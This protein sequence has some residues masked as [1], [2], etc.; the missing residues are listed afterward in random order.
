MS[1]AEAWRVAVLDEHTAGT[2]LF[3]GVRCA[4]A[5]ANYWTYGYFEPRDHCELPGLLLRTRASAQAP[6]VF[7]APGFEGE[8]YRYHPSE[9]PA[10]VSWTVELPP[11]RKAA[12]RPALVMPRPGPWEV[13][14]EPRRDRVDWHV[15]AQHRGRQIHRTLSGPLGAGHT[16]H[17]AAR[18][19]ALRVTVPGGA[20]VEVEHDAY[21]GPFMVAFGSA[22]A[23]DG[24]PV[25]TVYREVAV[26]EVPYPCADSPLPDG[27]EDLRAADDAWCFLVNE[28]TPEG[29]RQSEGDLAVLS[30]GSLLL[31]WTDYH[32][33]K[34]WD[35]SPA[36]LSARRSTDGGRT[37]SRK[38]TVVEEEHDTNV[39]SASLLNLGDELLLVYYDQLPDMPAKGMVARRSGD[40]GRSWSAA[41][42]ITPANGNRHAANNASLRRLADGRILLAAR[43]YVD[44]VR[45]PYCLLSDDGGRTWRAGSHV[46]DPGL[47]ER[48]RRAQ[49]V[50]EPSV[51]QLADGR[52][53][54]TMRS[55]SGGQFFACSEDRGQ[56][57]SRPFLSPLRGACSPAAIQRVPGTADVLCLWTY[58]LSGRTPL[59]SALSS[60]AGRSWRALKLVERSRHHGYCYTSIT[61]HGDR[62]LLTY[63][64]F[65][66]LAGLRRFA[67]EPGYIDL[68]LTALPVEW[69]YRPVT[70]ANWP[71]VS[72]KKPGPESNILQ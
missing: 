28:A 63:S 23:A 10:Y 70:E 39:M 44:G 67:V 48:E 14:A 72:G 32:A 41:A 30:D 27:P 7:F 2:G 3:Q 65:P 16:V 24:S 11:A 40:G 62:V 31:V 35:D 60:D 53:L 36:R 54:M 68:R 64:H 55:V 45:W 34:G 18:P 22:A 15:R 38:W 47:P 46:P 49:N 58:G 8:P 6:H 33:G 17:V 59:V 56:S 66:E 43:E 1:D 29:P 52:L 9:L 37:W 26:E 69:F 71:R 21:P 12:G 5:V 61:F 25:E 50:N 20:T 4:F 19:A 51:A 13:W 42:A 57:W